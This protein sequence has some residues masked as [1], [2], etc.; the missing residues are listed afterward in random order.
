LDGK[1]QVWQLGLADADPDV[2]LAAEVDD[3]K[4]Q[5]RLWRGVREAA[6]RERALLLSIARAGGR[7]ALGR[8]MAGYY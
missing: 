5:R 2:H 8:H 6:R 7:V 1:V 3:L 4:V